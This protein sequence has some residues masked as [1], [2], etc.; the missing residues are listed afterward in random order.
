MWIYQQANWPHF[1]WD[2]DYLCERLAQIRFQKGLLLGRMHE[3]G[4]SFQQEA[5]LVIL[6]QDIVKSSAIEGEKLNAPEVRSSIVRR[7]GLDTGGLLPINREVEGMVEMIVDATQHYDKPLTASRLFD[8]H[9]MLFPTGRSGMHRIQ[10]GQFRTDELGPMQV[11]SG[12]IGKEKVHF[13]APQASSLEKEMQRFLDW[14]EDTQQIDP[15]L[16]AGIAHFWF[17]TLHPFDDGNGRIARAISDL[18]L[19]RSESSSK[20]FYSLSSQIETERSSYYKQLEHQ[21]RGNLDI[22]AWLVWFLDCL[23][24]ALFNS[25]TTLNH[26]LFES[27]I[28]QIANKN[29]LNHR[30]KKILTSMLDLDFK[31][32]MNT[33]KYAKMTKCSNDTARSD[34][35]ELNQRGILEQNPFSEHNASYRLTTQLALG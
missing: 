17:I 10:V 15:V 14:F 32:H 2:S 28:W 7:L 22:T 33:S 1:N 34:L 3:L 11:V 24:N 31:G 5:H 35:L 26:I 25:E 6:T 9:T 8:W 16:K 13:Q 18:A 21:Q 30:Q 12:A 23:E 19:A 4:L 27:N 29:P 20:R